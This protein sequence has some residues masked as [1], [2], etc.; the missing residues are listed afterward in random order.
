MNK[1]YTTVLTLSGGLFTFAM[2]I[3]AAKGGEIGIVWRTIAVVI[4]GLWAISP[5]LGMLGISRNQNK[6]LGQKILYGVGFT[7][8]VAFGVIGLID[9]FFIHSDAQNALLFVFLPLYQWLG[10]AIVAVISY[11]FNAKNGAVNKSLKRDAAK[12]RRT[13]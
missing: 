12:N 2:L 1:A 6:N 7:L 3:Y 10:I 8:I 11:S 4:I 9:G 13:P 5:Y